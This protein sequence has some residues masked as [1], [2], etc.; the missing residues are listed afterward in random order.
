MNINNSTASIIVNIWWYVVFLFFFRV[1]CACTYGFVF[2]CKTMHLLLFS[3]IYALLAPP[4]T[5]CLLAPDYFLICFDLSYVFS[6]N[7]PVYLNF[8]KFKMYS[9]CSVWDVTR[10]IKRSVLYV[11]EAVSL[12]NFCLDDIFVC[13]MFLRIICL[14]V[15]F[16]SLSGLHLV[17]DFW[18]GL[19][20]LE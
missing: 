9:H 14:A 11:G 17:L 12:V 6:V 8:I 18:L 4:P 1:C 20:I 3:W 2:V 19:I 5:C 13:Q 10:A 16:W 7:H 15:Q